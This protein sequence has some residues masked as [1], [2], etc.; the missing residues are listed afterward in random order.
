[1]QSAS[2]PFAQQNSP[3][4]AGF[5]IAVFVFPGLG[6]LAY[7]GLSIPSWLWPL[8]L[9]IFALGLLLHFTIRR[10][11]YIRSYQAAVL[12]LVAITYGVLLGV[13]LSGNSLTGVRPFL[14]L[15]TGGLQILTGIVVF[16]D[17]RR[18]YRTNSRKPFGSYGILDAKTGVVTR[19]T[20][21]QHKDQEH[22]QTTLYT[23]LSRLAPMTAGLATL[24]VRSLSDS[25]INITIGLIALVCA[26][27]AAG[28]TGGVIFYLFTSANW[29][30]KHG[31]RMY[32]RR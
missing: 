31:M 22:R 1:M 20:S 30:Q 10:I 23:K 11:V 25:G 8:G 4:V 29:E 12:G 9:V 3:L 14:I 32:V 16:R 6:L 24:I 2:D 13:I 5:A 15:S 7:L 17:N 28:G 18:R 27:G 26:F 21:N 19:D